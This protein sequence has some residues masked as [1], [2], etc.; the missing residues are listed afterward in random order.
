M[1]LLR[2]LNVRLFYNGI[3]RNMHDRFS[4]KSYSNDRKESIARKRYRTRDIHLSVVQLRRKQRSF[5]LFSQ[6]ISLF[7]IYFAKKYSFMAYQ[8]ISAAFLRIYPVY[9][10][11]MGLE[12]SL[13]DEMRTTILV[14]VNIIADAR[15]EKSS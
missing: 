10:I 7:P 1:I 14:E 2:L 8:T 15:S 12:Y 13:F 3:I 6:K 4:F 11:H 9:R 5:G